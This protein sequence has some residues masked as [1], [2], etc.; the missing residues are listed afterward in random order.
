[1]KPIANDINEQEVLAFLERNPDF[2][3]HHV[4]TLKKTN[5]PSRAL[6]LGVA[7]FQKH[8][9]K[10]LRD[11][12]EEARTVT[13]Y[14]VE[15]SR[16]NISGMHRTFEVILRLLECRTFEDVVHFILNDMADI[17]NVDCIAIGIE[18]ET[19]TILPNS[20]I[21]LL[22]KGT[23]DSLMPDGEIVLQGGFRDGPPSLYHGQAQY[24][25]SH[26]MCPLDL[27]EGAPKAI[28][29]FAS[30]HPEGFHPDQA[31]DLIEFLSGTISRVI[32]IWLNQ[33]VLKM[34]ESS[35]SPHPSK[36]PS[37]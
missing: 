36:P 11:D 6:G 33:P 9:I 35:K 5:P 32:H 19:T 10:R 12:I 17:L 20:N 21:A 23:I 2:L 27:G 8:M 15:H 1:M 30:Q 24:I 29:A 25:H 13:Q 22:G 7:D 26:A 4:E 18:T 31:T 3:S 34:P 16:D 14:L 28:I 37:S